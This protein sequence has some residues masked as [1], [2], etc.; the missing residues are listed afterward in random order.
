MS[1]WI[2]SAVKKMKSNGTQGAFGK[3]TD[4]KIAAGKHAGGLQEKRAIFAENMKHI[5]EHRHEYY[6]SGSAHEHR[7]NNIRGK[8]GMNNNE[9]DVGD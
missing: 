4:S 7:N 5:S 1:Q 2:Q 6:K 9:K 8:L 3:A